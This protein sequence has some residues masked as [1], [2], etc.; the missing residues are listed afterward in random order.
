MRKDLENAQKCLRIRDVVLRE[1][2][3]VVRDDIDLI[4]FD[5]ESAGEQSFKS[6]GKIEE[7]E[8]SIP[9]E[10]GSVLSVWVY[11]FR[12][13]TGI[14]VV[15]E[16]EFDE[17]SNNDYEPAIKIM[18]TFESRYVSEQQ[19]T[20]DELKAF[21]EDNVAFNVWPFWREYVQSTCSRLGM[22]TPLSVPLYRLVKENNSSTSDPNAVIDC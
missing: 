6:T 2:T 17:V 10:V 13:S 14:R 12:L 15:P 20:G 16:N 8:A 5:L 21:S 19:L 1:S 22:Q 7:I 18:A 9:S 11:K 3:I 4:Q